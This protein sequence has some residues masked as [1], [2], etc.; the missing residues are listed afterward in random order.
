MISEGI[1]QSFTRE[2]WY[3]MTV[4]NI[5]DMQTTTCHERQQHEAEMGDKRYIKSH[6][7]KKR[8]LN[9]PKYEEINQEI[10]H[11]CRQAKEKWVEEKYIAIEKVNNTYNTRGVRE[12]IE[13][14]TKRKLLTNSRGGIGNTE[15][16]MIIIEEDET[17]TR[18]AEY[19]SLLN[20]DNI[21]KKPVKERTDGP[22]IIKVQA[23]RNIGRMK[24][25]KAAGSDGIPIEIIKALNEFGVDKIAEICSKYKDWDINLKK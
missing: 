3:K 14:I 22:P 9:S 4:F 12:E 25:V 19:I 17:T 6:E 21:C 23:E 7:R 1:E 24:G 16:Q 18:W 8:C 13:I 15:G 2:N 11:M 10:G 5:Q 20:D